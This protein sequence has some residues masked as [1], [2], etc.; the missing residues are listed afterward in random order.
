M[1]FYNKEEEKQTWLDKK[2]KII[3]LLSHGAAFAALA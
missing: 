3:R 2:K 1:S